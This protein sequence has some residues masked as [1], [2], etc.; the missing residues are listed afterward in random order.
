MALARQAAFEKQVLKVVVL[1]AG[2]MG[3]C[4]NLNTLVND[5]IVSDHLQN[6]RSSGVVL[7][8]L[9]SIY[10]KWQQGK[11][12]SRFTDPWSKS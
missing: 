1:K 8:T 11:E 10:Q 9:V 6:S 2:K 3:K 4:I 5:Q 12:W 7:D